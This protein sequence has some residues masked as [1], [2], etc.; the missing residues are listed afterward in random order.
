MLPLS[1][2]LLP[3]ALLLVKTGLFRLL[4]S[5]CLFLPFLF[6]F[7]ADSLFLG[8]ALDPSLILGFLSL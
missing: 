3:F 4:L 1:L 2:L 6:L 8:L 7:D 5:A